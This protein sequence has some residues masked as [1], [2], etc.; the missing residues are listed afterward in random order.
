M[1]IPISLCEILQFHMIIEFSQEQG[2]ILAK[3]R[4]Y[5]NELH[6]NILEHLKWYSQKFDKEFIL[7]SCHLAKV[8]HIPFIASKL[9]VLTPLGHSV[10]IN[11]CQIWGKTPYPTMSF[12][13]F[14]DNSNEWMTW[15]DWAK[16]S[17]QIQRCCKVP[18]C[19]YDAQ[20]YTHAIARIV[21][22]FLTNSKKVEQECTSTDYG[23]CSGASMDVWLIEK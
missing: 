13:D 23:K 3:R 20:G 6:G 18:G 2:L 14:K 4:A 21:S 5:K 9:G 11:K 19:R 12:W 7:Y 10:N 17:S 15:L 8:K 22:R 1:Y 16:F